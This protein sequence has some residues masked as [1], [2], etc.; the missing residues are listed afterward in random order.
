MRKILVAL[1]GLMSSFV[2]A[3]NPYSAYYTNM[4]IQIEQVQPVSVPDLQV[5]LTDFG[6]V[7]DGNTLATDAFE[8][9]IAFLVEQGG[10]HLIV[11]EGTFKTGPVELKSNIDLH[12][13]KGATILF[14]EDRS[15]FAQPL[16]NG[17]TR[18]KCD[19]CIRASH[20]ENVCITGQGVIDGQGEWWRPLKHNKA[21]D[22]EWAHVLELGGMVAN[23]VWYPFNLNNGIPNVADTYDQQEKMRTHLVNITDSKNV[24]MQGVTLKNAPKFHFV[25]SRCQNLIIDGVTV[26][27]PWNAQNGDAIDIGNTQVALVVNCNISCGDDGICMKGGVGEAGV[28]AGPNRDFLIMNDTVYRAHGGFVIGSEFSGGM[29]R[30]VVR[31]CHFDGTEVGLRFKSAP[32]RG[33]WCEDIWCTDIVMKDIAGSVVAFET[34][35]AD[36]GVVVSATAKDDKSAF[37]PDFGNFTFKNITCVGAKAAVTLSGLKGFPIHDILFEDVTILN[38]KSALNFKFAERITFKNCTIR[39]KA[40]NKLEYR[41]CRQIIYNGT[42]LLEE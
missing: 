1:F 39:S 16:P 36:R 5:V 12:L 37:F 6:A 2:M 30:L 24:L 3:Q 29:Q 14:S 26:R 23:D 28:K 33:G 22:E 10:G 27:C 7:P 25:P 8:K 9:A 20:A 4:P 19:P 21:T 40:E 13:N 15:L 42:D 18:T 32:G 11:P 17:K 34:G 41:S 31:N 35:Y 38:A